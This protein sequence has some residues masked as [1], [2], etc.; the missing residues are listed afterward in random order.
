[1]ALRRR[2]QDLYVVGQEF[3][4]NDGR[5]DP[6]TI[7]LRKLNPVD[8]ENAMRRANAARS[9]TQA[10]RSQPDSDEYNDV[11]GSVS[12]FEREGLIQYLAEEERLNRAAVVEAERA[13]D[14][15]WT[16]DG[17]LDGLRDAWAE[18]LED[19]WIVDNSD[20]E[21]ARV[22]SELNRFTGLVDKEIEAEIES[23]KQGLEDRSD[24]ALRQM[25]L[26]RFLVVRASLAWL[27]EYRRCEI[28]LSARELDKRT[29]VFAS[30]DEVDEL[31]LE[32]FQQLTEAYRSLAMDPMEGKDS[33]ATGSSSRSSVPPASPEMEDTCG[34]EDAAA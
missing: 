1:M 33:R 2:L 21:A 4:F 18:G 19:R 11:Y 29:K 25:V 16:K 23:F 30:R 20:P 22:W 15:E 27:S 6:V 3:T 31:P 14:E 10:V 28:W 13:S 17:Y 7:Y 8:H 5:G 32:M 24:E 26:E 12:E 9:R 34:P